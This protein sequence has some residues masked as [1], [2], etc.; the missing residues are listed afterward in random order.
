MNR[1]TFIGST[2]G[3]ALAATGIRRARAEMPR[4]STDKMLEEVEKLMHEPDVLW[5]EIAPIE[6]RRLTWLGKNSD[7]DN[8]E[9][10]TGHTVPRDGDTL[11]FDPQFQGAD[12]GPNNRPLNNVTVIIKAD[13]KTTIGKYV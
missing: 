3:A 9:N 2:I 5:K 1:R 11:V 6:P 10:W 4:C 13:G 7:F 8:P 12:C